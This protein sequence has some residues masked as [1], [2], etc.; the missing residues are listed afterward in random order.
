MSYLRKRFNGLD[1][2][3]IGVLKMKESSRRNSAGQNSIVTLNLYLENVQVARFI[4]RRHK[5]L[6]LHLRNDPQ[7]PG[8][9][10]TLILPFHGIHISNRCRRTF[11]TAIIHVMNTITASKQLMFCAKYFPSLEL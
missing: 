1:V 6:H 2:G 5:K 8:N 10:Y 9:G 7:H 3:H 11:D 4:K